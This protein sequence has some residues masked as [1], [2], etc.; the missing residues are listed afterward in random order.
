MKYVVM[1]CHPAYAVLLD[2][3]GNFIKAANMHY[4]VGQ[5]VTDINALSVSASYSFSE[6]RRRRRWIYLFAAAA[7]CIAVILLPVIKN[8][9]IY[10]S[11]Y[12]TINPQIRIDVNKN[13]EVIDIEGFNPE[14]ESFIEGYSF[15]NKEI[16]LVVKELADMAIEKGFL[17]EGG[18][19]TVD[20]DSEDEKWVFYHEDYIAK[21]LDDFIGEKISAAIEVEGKII[22]EAFLPETD[23]EYNDDEEY[24]D[25]YHDDECDDDWED[26]LDDEDDD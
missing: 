26:D 16:G 12:M 3:D 18:K 4:E 6:K 23:E 20:L 11:V 22:R 25:E 8:A 9:Q 10:A 2:E 1:E 24:D 15:K 17:S 5:V 7:V 14:G 13:D 19:I 21:C